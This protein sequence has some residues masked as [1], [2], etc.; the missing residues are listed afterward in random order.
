MDLRLSQTVS[1]K[2]WRD[3]IP[4]GEQLAASWQRRYQ[5]WLST[6]SH[7]PVIDAYVQ[8]PVSAEA[9]TGAGG[10]SSGRRA[11][12]ARITMARKLTCHL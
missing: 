7:E 5:R 1:V 8:A 12:I 9:G 4:G 11:A 3:C 2:G 6:P 10:G